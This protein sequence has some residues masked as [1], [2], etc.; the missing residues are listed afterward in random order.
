[1]YSS[2]IYWS[3]FVWVSIIQKEANILVYMNCKSDYFV[4]TTIK[5]NK[6][7]TQ[8]YSTYKASVKQYQWRDMTFTPQ[9]VNY[10]ALLSFEWLSLRKVAI[11]STALFDATVASRIILNTL[12]HWV[13]LVLWATVIMYSGTSIRRFNTLS[14]FVSQYQ[15]KQGNIMRDVVITLW[16][17]NSKCHRRKG[18]V[19]QLWLAIYPFM[20]QETL[21][22][23]WITAM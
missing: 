2:P 6:G 12:I 14:S 3:L 22:C 1:M 9:L 19:F 17:Q 13:E 7:T 23:V 10:A 8:S 4:W 16:A 18:I 15:I 20:S 11:N 21:L 5:R